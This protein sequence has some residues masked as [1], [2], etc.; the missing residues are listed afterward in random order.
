MHSGEQKAPA[1]SLT[2][3]NTYI[4]ILTKKQNQKNMFEK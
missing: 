1:A 3:N 2:T 4:F